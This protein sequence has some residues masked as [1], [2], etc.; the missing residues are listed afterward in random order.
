MPHISNEEF[1]VQLE[2]LSKATSLS[3]S[4]SLSLKRYNEGVNCFPSHKK[5]V[6][7]PKQNHCLIRAVCKERKI[8]TIVPTSEVASFNTRISGV[9]RGSITNLERKQ[10][11]AKK[12][13]E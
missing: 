7:D 9:L 12:A 13:S 6:I 3:G 11:K 5:E 8:S 1:L 10:K 4:V 2:K